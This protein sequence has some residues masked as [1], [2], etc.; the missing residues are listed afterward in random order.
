MYGLLSYNATDTSDRQVRMS[1]IEQHSYASILNVLLSCLRIEV[2]S[3]SYTLLNRIACRIYYRKVLQRC[4]D[5]RVHEEA[6][7]EDSDLS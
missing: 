1:H 3:S 5:G 2:N 4:R 7:E 6:K